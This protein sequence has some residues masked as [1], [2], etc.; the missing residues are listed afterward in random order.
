M[1][2]LI[3]L[4]LQPIVELDVDGVA[5]AVLVLQMKRR[6]QTVEATAG[7]DRDVISERVRLAHTHTHG[8]RGRVGLRERRRE[9]LREA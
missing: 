7:H 6:A 4:L 5:C 9:R 2:R 1:E 8:A 3:N